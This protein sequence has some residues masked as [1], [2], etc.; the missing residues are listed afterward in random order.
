MFQIVRIERPW[1][2]VALT[3]LRELPDGRVSTTAIWNNKSFYG[4][5]EAIKIAARE[6][7]SESDFDGRLKVLTAL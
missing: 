3:N 5:A 4:D 6:S 7:N 2:I 1:G